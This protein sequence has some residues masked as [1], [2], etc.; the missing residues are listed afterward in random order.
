M[1]RPHDSN[2]K[3]Q[4]ANLKQNTTDVNVLASG[5]SV[6]NLKTAL[7]EIT[8]ASARAQAICVH[9]AHGRH[10]AQRS[11][12]FR[13][14]KNNAFLCTPDGMPMVWTGRLNGHR[15][16]S[17]VYGP[18]L[19]L[20]LAWAKKA[21]PHFFLRRHAEDDQELR[22]KMKANFQNCKSP[23]YTPPFRALKADDENPAEQSPRRNWTLSGWA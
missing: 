11:P 18:D 12:A 1:I 17:R 2:R 21:V 9:D 14:I 5:I 23:A 3:P 19:M 7:A 16:M 6:L 8:A 4:T 22:D 10:E 15:E 13:R 20:E